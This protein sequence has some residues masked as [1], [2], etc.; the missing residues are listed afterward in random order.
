MRPDFVELV[1]RAKGGDATAWEALVD[2]L[3]GIVWSTVSGFSLSAEDRNDVFAAS[4]FRLYER[5]DTVREPHKLPGWMATTTRHEALALAR[6]RQRVQ[7]HDDLGEREERGRALDERLLD[8]ELQLAVSA[9]FERLSPAHQKLLRMLTAEPPLSYDQ[10]AEQL[11]IPRGS[12][13]PTRQRCLERLRATP[14]LQPFLEG[15]PR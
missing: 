4:F 3:T 8:D 5:L 2:A 13:G 12:I 9:A 14:E 1:E 10:I 6:M 15:G 7:P 11:E